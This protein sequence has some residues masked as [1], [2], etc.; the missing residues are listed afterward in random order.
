MIEAA[1]VTIREA[2][3]VDA[4]AIRALSEAS[5]DELGA[6]SQH[7]H[8]L[9]HQIDVG[10]VFVAETSEGELVGFVVFN[11]N[12]PKEHEHTT[13]YYLCVN[14]TYRKHGIGKRLMEAVA[15]D[16]RLFGNRR[17]TLKCPTQLA[18]NYFYQ[19]IGYTL[20]GSETDQEGG[21]LNFWTLSL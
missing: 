14:S 1:G 10:D 15:V 19:S 2:S 12:P 3:Q 20:E 8:W 9:T 17:I 21:S 13:V 6:I 16:V 7:R 4:P 5:Q 11:H 18:A